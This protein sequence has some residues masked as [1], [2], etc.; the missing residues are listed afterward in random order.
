M[1]VT[2]TFEVQ[3]MIYTTGE[4]GMAEGGSS[5]SGAGVM[6]TDRSTIVAPCTIKKK[7]SSYLTDRHV[8]RQC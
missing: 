6:M 2:K 3:R 8:I 4:A 1:L 5:Y 7:F